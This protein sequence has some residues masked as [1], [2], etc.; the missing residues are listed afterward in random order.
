VIG[1]CKTS[2]KNMLDVKQALYLPNIRLKMV[3]RHFH[4]LFNTCLCFK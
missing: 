1:A 2:R 4:R 3:L